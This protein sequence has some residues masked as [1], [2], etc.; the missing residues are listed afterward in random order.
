[1]PPRRAQG[2][3]NY[4][5]FKTSALHY[6]LLSAL[7]FLRRSVIRLTV[8]FTFVCFPDAFSISDVSSVPLTRS[9]D[10]I[11]YVR[12]RTYGI[13]RVCGVCAENRR[14]RM[15]CFFHL[16]QVI[17]IAELF[18][19][20]T[21]GLSARGPLSPLSPQWF[22]ERASFCALSKSLQCA[23]ILQYEND[24][25]TE[26][27]ESREGSRVGCLSS[28]SSPCPGDETGREDGRL[29]TKGSGTSWPGG[30]DSISLSLS[31]SYHRRRSL[32][33]GHR[34]DDRR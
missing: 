20:W 17:N 7:R 1:M 27:E 9:L 14:A 25:G 19:K 11:S 16:S 6:P 23:A 34:E 21:R 24:E 15:L 33:R 3:F 22:A 29:K 10:L 8:C 18:H 4:L 32:S 13:D 12:Y 31:P 5:M 30:D 26:T 28:A 2:L